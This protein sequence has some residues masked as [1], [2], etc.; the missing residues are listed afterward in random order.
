[1][2]FTKNSHETIVF[3]IL[4]SNDQDSF[5]REMK[6]KDVYHSTPRSSST[7]PYAS[8]TALVYGCRGSK[9]SMA[10]FFSWPQPAIGP[11][12]DNCQYVLG[13][14]LGFPGPF[15]ISFHSFEFPNCLYFFG[16]YQ[17]CPIPFSIYLTYER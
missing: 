12:L 7:P 6:N 10:P 1:M 16:G 3:M 13:V 14:L 15:V 8:F 4:W 5:C 11:I 17:K 9:I 2:V